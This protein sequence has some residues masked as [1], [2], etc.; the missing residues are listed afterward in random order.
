MAEYV[1]NSNKLK[2]ERAEQAALEERQRPEPVVTSGVKIKKRSKFAGAIISDD[3]KNVKSHAVMEIFIPALKK[4]VVDVVTDGVNMIFYGSKA[5]RGTSIADRVSYRQYSDPK[6]AAR[7]SSAPRPSSVYDCDKII[8]ASRTDA[9][10]VLSGLDDLIGTYG[11]ATV[12]DLYDLLNESH[13]YTDNNYGWYSIAEARV[14]P[15]IGGG[16]CL[17]LPRVVPIER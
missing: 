10:A 14:S 12:A 1:G 3:A 2:K 4:L 5:P 13:N 8:I 17:N 15:A 6:V 16:W 7:T 11:R 9:E